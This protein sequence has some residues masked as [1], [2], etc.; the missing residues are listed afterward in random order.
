[1]TSH[2]GRG[3]LFCVIIKSF[4]CRFVPLLEPNPGD[5]TEFHSP[6]NP[7]SLNA[8]SLR[9]LGFPKSPP[10][11]KI[12][13]PPMRSPGMRWPR[14]RGSS[15]PSRFR[16]IASYS[17]KVSDFNLPHLHL[18][19]PLAVTPV[20]F[21]GDLCRQKTRV[22]DLSCGFVPVILCVSVLVQ[23]RLVT[24]RHRHRHTAI[25]DIPL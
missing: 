10:S 23:H 11:K 21:R 15:P 19:P 25:A 18:T 6:V 2:C 17:P 24:D 9:S 12:L 22:P 8:R 1:V 16:H 20:E 4:R 3:S 7:D 5:A 13:D 14:S